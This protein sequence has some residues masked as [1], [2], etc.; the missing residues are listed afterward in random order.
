[1]ASLNQDTNTDSPL[2]ASTS[3]SLWTDLD[4]ELGPESISFLNEVFMQ[5]FAHSGSI[6]NIDANDIM[7]GA[8]AYQRPYEIQGIDSSTLETALTAYFDFASLVLPI[9][10]RDAFMAD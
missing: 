7:E 2:H 10:H 9:I 8:I 4:L 6:A 1:V 3:E 5:G